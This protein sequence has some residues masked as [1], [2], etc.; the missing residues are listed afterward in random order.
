M[1]QAMS[2]VVAETVACLDDKILC[3]LVKATSTA[4]KKDSPCSSVGGGDG[5]AQEEEEEDEKL[6]SSSCSAILVDAAVELLEGQWPRSSSTTAGVQPYRDMIVH[7]PMGTGE[8]HG[9]S[10]YGLPCSYL[11]VDGDGNC[12]G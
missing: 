11:L 8:D 12:S 10:H 6:S 4:T 1:T 2:I 7:H 5:D 9:D 3:R